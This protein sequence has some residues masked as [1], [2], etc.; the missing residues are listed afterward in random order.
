MAA[1]VKIPGIFWPVLP[2][3]PGLPVLPVFSLPPWE[4]FA[5]GAN[6]N[7]DLDSPEMVAAFAAYRAAVD[8]M[9]A[10]VDR[11]AGRTT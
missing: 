11:L 3:L 7:V 10:A 9:T 6:E 8:D 1:I 5:C 4:F 2:P